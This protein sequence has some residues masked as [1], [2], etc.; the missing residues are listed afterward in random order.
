[1]AYVPKITR[2]RFVLGPFSAEDM[3][4]IGTFMCDRIRRRIESGVNVEDNPSKALKPG[5]EKQKARR[6]LN[7]IRDWIWRGRTLRSLSVKNANENRVVIGF[8]DPE[9]DG[10]AHVNNLRERAFGVSPEDR[11]ALTEIVL[12]TLRTKRVVAFRKA[13]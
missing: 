2:A 3:T 13:A 4:I 5:Y 10:I 7:P 9:T 6:G 1:M 11:K 12:A 8:S